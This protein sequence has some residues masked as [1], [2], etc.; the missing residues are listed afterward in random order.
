MWLLCTR[1][2]SR[3]FISSN[4]IQSF[5][6]QLYD[7]ENTIIIHFTGEETEAERDKFS[8]HGHRAKWL[9][10]GCLHRSQREFPQVSLYHFLCLQTATL[11]QAIII[12]C[13]NCITVHVSTSKLFISLQLEWSFK[14]QSWLYHCSS[15]H[16]SG[17]L[18]LLVRMR[19]N[20]QCLQCP[21][22]SCL[23]HPTSILLASFP[24]IQLQWSFFRTLTLFRQTLLVTL[25]PQ[26]RT[27]CLLLL[28]NS[29]STLTQHKDTKHLA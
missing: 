27:L 5:Q 21:P 8:F 16:L 19:Q 18:L 29:L 10:T 28:V 20:L 26:P 14:T 12:F 3:C 4:L 6:Q 1:H 11:V 7:I 23:P 17:F 22:R 2:F 24:A 15:Y 9:K 25:F 13:L